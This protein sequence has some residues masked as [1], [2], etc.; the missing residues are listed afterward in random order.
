M[1][2][3]EGPPPGPSPCPECGGARVAA[4]AYSGVQ[5]VAS[6]SKQSS[7]LLA[8]VCVACGHT[9]FYAKEPSRMAPRQPGCT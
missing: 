6:R 4:D 3:S 9:T 7:E 1:T 8:L 5:I 2:A